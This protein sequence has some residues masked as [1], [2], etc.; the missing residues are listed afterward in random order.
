MLDFIILDAP[1]FYPNK[2]ATCGNYKGPVIDSHVE[3]TSRERVYVCQRCVGRMAQMFGL[4]AGDEQDRL[5]RSDALLRERDRE[6]MK[7]SE[8]ITKLTGERKQLRAEIGELQDYRAWAEGR[9]AQLEAVI[10]DE[11]K[12]RLALVDH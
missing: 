8:R 9:L 2:C 1:L 7:A 6:L 4:T 3:T 5:L 11:A 10:G 12:A